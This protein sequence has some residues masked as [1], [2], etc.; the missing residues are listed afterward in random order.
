MKMLFDFLIFAK[1]GHAD[2]SFFTT[3][4][5]CVHAL[6]HEILSIK[7]FAVDLDDDIATLKSHRFESVVHSTNGVTDLF[8]A[9]FFWEKT[10]EGA[11]GSE[12]A[13]ARNFNFG[14]F[15]GAFG[16]PVERKK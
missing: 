12:V 10:V 6:N 4:N 9:L 14:Q 5:N 3:H 11:L 2:F 1:E 16:E 15:F 8:V 7:F 13:Q